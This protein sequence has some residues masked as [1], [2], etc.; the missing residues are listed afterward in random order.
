MSPLP[1]A[2]QM[3]SVRKEFSADPLAT[4]RAV[5]EMGYVGVE[6]AGPPQFCP[7]L[8]TALLKE[9]GLVCC[10]WHTPWQMV[11]GE[12]LTA[13]IRL[14]QT[15]GNKYIIIPWLEAKTHAEWKAKAQ[16]LNDLSDQLAFFGMR[17]GYHNHAHDFTPL[18]GKPTMETLAENTK[19]RVILQLDTGNAM[20][21]GGDILAFLRQFPGRSQSIHLKPYSHQEGQ[22]YKPLIGDDQ[23]PWREVL[24]ICREH[25]DTDW[26]IVEYEHPDLPALEAVHSCLKALRSM[27]A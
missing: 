8:Y 9:T 18:D 6:F 20:A 22:G 14:N 27:I 26:A 11:Q 2:L 1:L 3:Y 25:G 4:M 15:V 7:E 12:S 24:T 23:V 10:G 21:G 19:R 13:T 17:T 5:K 16:E